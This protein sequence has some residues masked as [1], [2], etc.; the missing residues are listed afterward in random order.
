LPDDGAVLVW[1]PVPIPGEARADNLID[2]LL[3]DVP[4]VK[5]ADVEDETRTDLIVGLP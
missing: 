1:L 5:L 4:A 3:D 2:G